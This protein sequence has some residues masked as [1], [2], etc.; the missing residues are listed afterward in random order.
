MAGY[1]FFE[2]CRG[3]YEQKEDETP[4]DTSGTYSMVINLNI[5]A[6]FQSSLVYQDHISTDII[7]RTIMNFQ[8]MK[9]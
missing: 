7:E 4:D 6:L 5:R 3:Y 9:I 2:E 8:T 1:I